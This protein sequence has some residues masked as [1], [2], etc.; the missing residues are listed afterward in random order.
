MPTPAGSATAV[1]G[2][3]G[4]APHPA[5]AEP[6]TRWSFRAASAWRPLIGPWRPGL[7]FVSVMKKSVAGTGT[8]H[9][10]LIV[11]E[12]KISFRLWLRRRDNGGS[13]VISTRNHGPGPGSGPRSGGT[14]EH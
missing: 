13:D 12:Q 14:M 1:I 2:A 3:P 5:R 4:S 10:V 7:A 11:L 8:N 6:T 9:S